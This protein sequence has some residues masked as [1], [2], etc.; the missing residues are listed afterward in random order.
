VAA[1]ALLGACGGAADGGRPGAFVTLP[2]GAA[3]PSDSQCAA[4]VLQS[5]WEPRPDNATANQTRASA[6]QLQIFRADGWGGVDNRANAV[7]RQRVTG[8]FSGTTDE[9]IQWGAC[10]WGFDVNVIRAQAATESWWHQDAVGDLTADAALWPPGATCQD[11]AHCYQ[12]YGLLQI[13][14]TYWMSAWPASRDSTAFNVDAALGWR[15]TCYEGYIQWLSAPGTSGYPSYGPGDLWGCVGQW[16]SG[17]W[18]DP[19]AISYISNVQNNLRNQ[20][21]LGQYF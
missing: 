18:Y 4:R 16:F 8:A 21:W 10:K 2:P 6:S 15:R 12:S 3:L 5:S 20:V 1:A 14:W 7:L 17:G 19:G 11:G 9:I 13:K